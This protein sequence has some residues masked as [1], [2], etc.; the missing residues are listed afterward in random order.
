MDE[1][2]RK[3]RIP[4]MGTGECVRMN[5]WKLEGAYMNGSNYSPKRALEN[6]ISE[7]IYK[8]NALKF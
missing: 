8:H 4:F 7:R 3:K 6:H 1:K 5:E 2:K